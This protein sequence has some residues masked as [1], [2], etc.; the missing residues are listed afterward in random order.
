MPIRCVTIVLTMSTDIPDT[1]AARRATRSTDGRLEGS[2][3]MYKL[4]DQD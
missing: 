1:A 2:A 3:F 4:L